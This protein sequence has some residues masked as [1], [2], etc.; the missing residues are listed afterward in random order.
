MAFRN[1]VNGDD[2]PDR[3]YAIDKTTGAQ[4]AS[5]ALPIDDNASV[6]VTYHPGRN[7]IY[8]VD[9]V[10]A[11]DA[12]GLDAGLCR[13]NLPCTLSYNLTGKPL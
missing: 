3:V 11:T 10:S 2:A 4:L 9:S 5:V 12:G 6:G 7:S 1:A 8:V 13:C